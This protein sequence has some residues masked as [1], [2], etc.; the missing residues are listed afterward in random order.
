MV[1]PPSRRRDA[2]PRRLPGEER[3]EAVLAAA[4]PVFA[5]RGFAGTTTRDLAKAAG[6]TEP[7]LYRHFPSKAD[8]FLAVLRAA[9]DRMV[10]RLAAIVTGAAGAGAR[11]DA[12]ARAMGS[13]VETMSDELRL[14]HG[15]AA[16]QTEPRVTAAVRATY[17]R[18]AAGFAAALAGRGLRKGLSPAAA[19]T[20]LLELGVG[21]SLLGS[22]RVEGLY[23]S[24]YGDTARA[25]LLAALT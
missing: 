23:E 1:K 24:G 10:G 17:R 22:L 7:V 21:A 19:A 18:L 25:L 9:E 6:V 11:L 3:R 2:A 20:F 13:V 4:L 12:L 15:A 5:S 14:L 8:L 16:T